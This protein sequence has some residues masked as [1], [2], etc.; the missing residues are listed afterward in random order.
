M[1]RNFRS[2]F[3]IISFNKIKFCHYIYFNYFQTNL[4][5]F[6]QCKRFLFNLCSAE[7]KRIFNKF[8]SR[9]VQFW[10]HS[11]W[12]NS[13]HSNIGIQYNNAIDYQ[14]FLSVLHFRYVLNCAIFHHHSLYLGRNACPVEIWIHYVKTNLYVVDSFERENNSIELKKTVR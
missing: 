3:K 1:D 12:N 2:V 4:I 14:Y 8:I 5:C 7:L 6:W 10:K 11:S 9:Y 13:L